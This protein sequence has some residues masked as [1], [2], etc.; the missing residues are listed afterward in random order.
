MVVGIIAGILAFVGQIIGTAVDTA[1]AI[2]DTMLA[3]LQTLFTLLQSFIQSAP[4]PMKIFIFLFFLL[5]IGNV[6][7]GFLLGMRY[8]CDGSN[9]LYETENVVPALT[10]GLKDI[11]TTQSTADR[12]S[13]IYDNYN[14]RDPVVSP[15]TIKCVDNKPK[16]YFYSINIL[17]YTLWLFILVILF[18]VPMIW[19]YYSKMGILK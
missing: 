9:M 16:L 14:I 10:L 13:Y 1:K 8:A 11:F 7:S 3:F 4:T 17:S 15:T 19:G 2:V 5:T 6:F 12:N 18:G